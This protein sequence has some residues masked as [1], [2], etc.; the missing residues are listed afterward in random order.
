[1]YVEMENVTKNNNKKT[2]VLELP[3]LAPHLPPRPCISVETVAHDGWKVS[4]VHHFEPVVTDRR[5]QLDAHTTAGC[6]SG[7]VTQWPWRFLPSHLSCRSHLGVGP[8]G[9]TLK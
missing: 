6:W 9:P 5:V 3:A 2:G 8:L 1:M 4:F 7:G